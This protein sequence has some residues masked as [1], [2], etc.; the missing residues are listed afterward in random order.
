[1][2]RFQGAVRLPPGFR[3]H[4]RMRSSSWSTSSGR[5]SPPR[6]RPPLSP[7][8]S[9]PD[10]I[11]GIFLGSCHVTGG[12]EKERYFFSTREIKYPKGNRPNRASGAGYWKATGKDK[13]IL[14]GGGGGSHV[15]G[16]K[17]TL[18]FYR[19]KAPSGERTDWIM[20]EYRL[21]GAGE[22]AHVIHL[23]VQMK[24][25]VLCRVFRKRRATARVAGDEAAGHR[26]AGL[27]DFMA[28]ERRSSFDVAAAP[29][30]DSE[31]SCVTEVSGAAAA[32]GDADSSCSSPSS[33]PWRED[34]EAL[35]LS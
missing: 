30:S 18:V 5:S 10:S 17:K 15:V 27:I 33:P 14:A 22:E 11:L 1:M 3:F 24:D 20:H 6:C 13:Q 7:R 9:S 12:P 8:S 19:G 29:A 26:T 23:M 2:A 28:E 4:P 31:P 21:V 34:E 32:D 35:E 25:W 16:A